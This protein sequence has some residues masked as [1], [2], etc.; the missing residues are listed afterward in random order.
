MIRIILILSHGQTY[1]GRGFSIN[2]EVEAANLHE[3]SLVAYRRVH[4]GV[5][6]RECSVHEFPI[7]QS[8][9]ESCKHAR[10]RYQAHLDE[11]KKAERITTAQKKRKEIEVELSRIKAKKQKME[12]TALQLTDEA[13]L[14]SHEAEKKETISL[15]TKANA[16]RDRAKLKRKEVEELNE[17]IKRKEKKLK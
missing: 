11:R 17:E 3:E 15:L 4:D 16:L 1:I 8:L 10:I 12:Y 5:R 6:L 7:N 9:L 2:K 14:L 13:D